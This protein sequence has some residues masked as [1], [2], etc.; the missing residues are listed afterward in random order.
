MDYILITVST[1]IAVALIAGLVFYLRRKSKLSGND[2]L[3]SS[4][5][6]SSGSGMLGADHIQNNIIAIPIE[7]LPATTHIEEKR[8]FEITDQK[9]ISRISELIPFTSQTGTRLIG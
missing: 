9:V 7:L 1:I 2:A 8:L 6:S 4:A 3:V 5:S